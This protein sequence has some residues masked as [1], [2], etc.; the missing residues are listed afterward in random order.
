MQAISC[1]EL[2]IIRLELASNSTVR[3]AFAS[4]VLACF[5]SQ[6]IFFGRGEG[7]NAASEGIPEFLDSGRKCSTLG[8][9]RWILDA[10]L[11][12]LDSKCCILD[13]ARYTLEPGLSP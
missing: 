5:V 13:A 11:W 10:E 6:V 4:R 9:G 1:L 2:I 8:S 3:Y 7:A 12:T